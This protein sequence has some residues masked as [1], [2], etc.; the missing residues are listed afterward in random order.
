MRVISCAI[1]VLLT[2]AIWESVKGAKRQNNLEEKK[3]SV[4]SCFVHFQICIHW[5]NK[6]EDISGTS[7]RTDESFNA[8]FF[9]IFLAFMEELLNIL[10]KL[11]GIVVEDHMKKSVDVMFSELSCLRNMTKDLCLLEKNAFVI[12]LRIHTHS[13]YGANITRYLDIATI[14]LLNLKTSVTYKLNVTDLVPYLRGYTENQLVFLTT[15]LK[16]VSENLSGTGQCQSHTSNSSD[17]R[18]VVVLLCDS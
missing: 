12:W 8:I 4:V 1:C 15:Q 7:Y 9:K 17:Y 10:Q 14:P 6:Q 16:I 5:Y 3:I 11:C 13:E 18:Y 2:T